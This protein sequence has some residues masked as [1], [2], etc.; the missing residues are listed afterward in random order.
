[1]VECPKCDSQM[2]TRDR[3]GIMIEECREC[4]GVYLDRGEL[5]RLIDA[6]SQY[7]ATLP[8][9]QNAETTYQGRHRH[10]VVQQVFGDSES[11]VLTSDVVSS[12]T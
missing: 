7:L 10:G 8:A 9:E 4:R 3:N 12:G 11:D 6:E 1:M 2:V 5:E